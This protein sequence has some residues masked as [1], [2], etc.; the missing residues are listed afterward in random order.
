VIIQITERVA[1]DDEV[2]FSC[3]IARAVELVNMGRSV[4]VGTFFEAVEVLRDLGLTDPSIRIMIE[5]ALA[6]AG[7]QTRNEVV[8]ELGWGG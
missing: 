2:G 5:A 7:L 8:A 6:K 4:A 3:D 1:V